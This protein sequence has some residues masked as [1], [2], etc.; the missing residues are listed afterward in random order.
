MGSAYI[1]HPEEG[2]IGTIHIR[3]Q[4]TQQADQAKTLS[5]TQDPRHAIET[6]RFQVR[7]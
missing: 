1:H 7:Y 2:W 5:D 4:G 6:R 3:L